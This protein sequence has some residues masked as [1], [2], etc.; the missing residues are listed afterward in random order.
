MPSIAPEIAGGRVTID[1]GAL[2]RNYRLLAE[3]SSGAICG[4]AV[5]GD[6]YGIGLEP[7]V[8]TLLAAGCKTFFVALPEEGARARRCAPQ[9]DIYMLGGLFEGAG[10]YYAE[11]NLRPVLNSLAEIEE[12]SRFCGD[13][14]RPLASAVHVDTG[15]NRLG[16]SMDEARAL[17][18]QP[19]RVAAANPALLMSHLACGDAPEHPLNATQVARFGE[20]RALFPDIPASLANSAGI[21]GNSA[22]RFDIV[23]PGIALYGG[24]SLSA[25]DNPMNPVVT[26]EAR[27]VLVRD[28]AAGETV[29]YGALETAKRQSRV[30]ILAVGYADGYL[31]AAGSTDD[32]P[33]A[34][35][36]IGGHD[37][38]LI[39]RVSM[40]LIAVDVTGVP[41]T[42]A[43]RGAW[44]E[45]IGPNMPLDDVAAR[46]GTIGY[47]LLTSIG[48]RYQRIYV[49][50]AG[51]GR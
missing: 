8:E 20:I 42:I 19:D 43:K 32:A 38:P 17:A 13:A 9:A 1:L 41:E 37:V 21:L 10:Q 39:G 14:G 40:D 34:A 3:R 45:L 26:L 25:G 18:T 6:G 35:G 4:A 31:R 22:T 23:R 5:K 36:H 11:H 15:F 30:A 47:E 7:A 48:H 12:W 46:A 44:V 49:G 24:R 29:G 50:G 33:G 16:L 28:V 51:N 2:A 27:I